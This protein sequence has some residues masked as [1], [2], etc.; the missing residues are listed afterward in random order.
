MQW[1]DNTNQLWLTKYNYRQ[2]GLSG[3]EGCW[4][5]GLRGCKGCGVERVMRL[6]WLWGW[7]GCG[8][9]RAVGLKGLWD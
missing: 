4:L 3:S 2:E 8:V 7:S 9:E 5:E 6:E 1:N